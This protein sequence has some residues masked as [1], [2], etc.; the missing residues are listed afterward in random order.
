MPYNTGKE[1][2]R[3]LVIL[4]VV[5]FPKLITTKE[6]ECAQCI[7]IIRHVLT[8]LLTRKK[9]TMINSDLKIFVSPTYKR[10]LHIV[11][12]I[13]EYSLVLIVSLSVIFS[14]LFSFLDHF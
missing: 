13:L 12:D 6:Y 4:K 14:A 1:T 10:K 2:L 3:P 11:H 8:F 7:A 5:S 9:Y